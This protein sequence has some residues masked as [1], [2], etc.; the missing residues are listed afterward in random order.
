MIE[1]IGNLNPLK[2][3]RILS[4]GRNYLKSL[5]GVVRHHRVA[6]IPTIIIKDFT[7][8]EFSR[9][10]VLIRWKRFGLPTIKLRNL[11]RV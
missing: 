11:P 7:I 2:C 6:H 1:R 4:I 3:L 5:A 10:H 8:Y 9:K